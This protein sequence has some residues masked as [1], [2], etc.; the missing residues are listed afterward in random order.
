M[1]YVK[2]EGNILLGYFWAANEKWKLG[3]FGLLFG[4][5]QR[6]VFRKFDNRPLLLAGRT[7]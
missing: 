5:G 7:I 2:L 6:D 4:R 3:N 1:G